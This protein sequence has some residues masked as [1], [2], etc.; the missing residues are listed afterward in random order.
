[1]I[2]NQIS[3]LVTAEFSKNENISKSSNNKIIK[4]VNEFL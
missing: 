2:E 1:M 4:K 3:T